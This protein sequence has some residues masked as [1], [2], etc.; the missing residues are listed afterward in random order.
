MNVWNHPVFVLL[1]IPFSLIYTWI[2]QWRNRLYDI[3][4]FKIHSV[5]AQVVSVGNLTVGGTGKT[6]VVEAI[7]RIYQEHGKRVAVQSRGYGRYLKGTLLVSDEKR[8]LAGPEQAG[9]EPFLLAKH[10]PGVPVIV[11]S[12]RYDALCQVVRQFHPDVVILDDAFQHR[13]IHRDI[14]VVTID[15]LKPYGNGR[16]IPAGPLREK[17]KGL[18]RADLII[19]TRADCIEEAQSRMSEIIPYTGA[20]IFSSVHQPVSWMNL[21]LN[22][23]YPLDFINGKLVLAMAGIGNPDAFL[24]TLR[25]LNIEPVDFIRF[26]DHY[27]YKKKDVE[28][29]IARAIN[30]SAMAVLTTEKDG[31]RML[32]MSHFDLPV[33]CLKIQCEFHDYSM[34]RNIFDE[35][36]S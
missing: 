34:V 5:G 8:L 10:L 12:D 33:Y 7:A 9:D 35:K 26:S 29:I 6:P 24:A 13:R 28:K 4:I 1:M 11:S 17:K 15:A 21:Q 30:M 18:N 16:I 14:D 32:N 22:K 2:M 25:Q 19:Q 3:G 27:W 23:M 20:P 31:V 36:K